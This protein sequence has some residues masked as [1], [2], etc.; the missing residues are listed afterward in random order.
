MTRFTKKA[1]AAKS[2]PFITPNGTRYQLYVDMLDQP[3]LLIA[4]T[5]G[6]GKSVIINSL[7][8]TALFNPPG[9]AAGGVQFILIDPKRV[10]LS[11]YR[12]LPHTIVYAADPPERL[13]ALQYALSITESRFR[14]MQVDQ[15]RKYQGGHVYVI[16]DEY[17]DLMTTQKRDTMPI[18]QRLAQ[19]GRA[20]RVHVILAT[21]TPISRILPTEIKC[22]FDSRVGLRTRST[23][24][25]R[26]IIGRPGLETL[27]RQGYG[28]YM[29]PDGDST[30]KIP[31]IS[32]AD[33][34]ARVNHWIKQR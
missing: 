21:Q 31:M 2:R 17:A 1:R 23:Q 33:I 7:I 25:S 24:D 5:T 8:Y 32:D 6:S 4:G 16:I 12:Y 26:N 30:I 10:E 20:A 28:V 11:I 27:P 18:V 9:R 14:Q 13:Y 15:I 29:T 19:I 3:H 34:I 22:N